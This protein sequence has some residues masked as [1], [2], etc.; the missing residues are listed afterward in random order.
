MIKPRIYFVP[1]NIAALK[2]YERLILH[3]EDRYD[4]GFLLVRHEGSLLSEMAGYCRARGRNFYI[5][6]LGSKTQRGSVPFISPIRKMLAHEKSC[7][8]FLKNMRPAKL[9]FEKTTNPMSSIAY[10][11]NHQGVE[12]IVLQWCFL[13]SVQR[14]L[15][16]H[17][18]APIPFARREYNRAVLALYGGVRFLAGATEGMNK[19]R[20]ITPRKLG[21]FEEHFATRFPEMPAI[22]RNVGNLDIQTTNELNRRVL[23]DAS[24]RAGLEIKYSLETGKKNILVFSARILSISFPREKYLEYYKGVFSEL[25][26]HFPRE[27]FV[28]LFKLHPKEDLEAVRVLCKEYD[29]RA[30]GGEADSGELTVLSHLVVADP[31]SSVNYHVLGSGIP[32]IFI[33]FSGSRTIEA[34]K[35]GLSIKH[36]VHDREE[37]GTMLRS[38]KEGRLEKQYD[39]TNIELRSREKIVELINA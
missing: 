8:D 38:F 5:L 6:N 12:T 13:S 4:V 39:N 36:V 17:E 18:K 32:A 11:A 31:M 14:E 30:Y 24:F 35:D 34:G 19:D 26:A 28:V 3:L 1:P 20:H 9:I 7:H 16:M 25:R 10:E 15:R 22:V 27:E 23:G 37:F 21:L 2:Y 33:N 29:A